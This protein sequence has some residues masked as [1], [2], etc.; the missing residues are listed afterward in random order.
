MNLRAIHA[1]V[2]EKITCNSMEAGSVSKLKE[3]WP[4]DSFVRD[5]WILN[6]YEHF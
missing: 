4:F 1:H 6:T 3:L 2:V 5:A